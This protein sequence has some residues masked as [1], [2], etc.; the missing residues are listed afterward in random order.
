[1]QIALF[2]GI[3]GVGKTTLLRHIKAKIAASAT[4]K[5]T[6]LFYSEHMTERVF[7][8]AFHSGTLNSVD[9]AAHMTQLIEHLKGLETAMGSSPFA[10][11]SKPICQAFIERFGI[12]HCLKTYMTLEDM[13]QVFAELS[14]FTTPA[15]LFH[16]TLPEDHIQHNIAQ[17]LTHRNQAWTDYVESQGG[18]DTVVQKL[19]AEQKQAT[20]LINSV[21]N[22]TKVVT[23][24]MYSPDYDALADTV[25][26]TMITALPAFAP[27]KSA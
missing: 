3:S 1:M 7:E 8:P 15:T 18:V 23:L 4:S 20:N 27:Q 17:S 22:H 10:T 24:D 21:Q 25:L 5:F 12:S 16:L 2:E 19:V 9:V 14:T 11:S 13:Q 6:H 26:A